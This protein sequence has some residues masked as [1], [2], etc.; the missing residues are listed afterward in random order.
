MDAKYESSN[1]L[2]YIYNILMRVASTVDSPRLSLNMFKYR[3]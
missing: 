3:N 2:S 1:V